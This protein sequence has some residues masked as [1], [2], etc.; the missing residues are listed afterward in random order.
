MGYAERE[1]PRSLSAYVRCV[2]SYEAPP[3]D[4]IQR[5]VPDG[6]PELIVHYGAPYAEVGDSG[7]ATLQP[8]VLFAG[9][10]TRPLCLRPSGRSGV[11]GIRFHPH[12]GRSFIGTP[13]HETTDSRRAFAADLAR[14]VAGASDEDQ[15]IV[16]VER[17]VAERVTSLGE[18]EDALVPRLVAQVEAAGGR[19]ELAELLKG[20]GIGRRQLERRFADAVGIGPALF[21]AIVR[22]R[23][24]FDV[25]EREGARPWT[26]AALEAGYYD[27]SHFIREF[28]RFV[29]CTPTEFEAERSGLASALV[30]S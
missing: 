8:S 19:I 20:A 21:A 10:L 17:F 14:L 30:D 6:C 25:L 12:A 23:R 1:P 27:Q 2:W 18:R 4:A 15:R 5:I 24:V 16:H 26:E 3:T 28:K 29:G 13:M 11:V 9:Q 22:F 7:K